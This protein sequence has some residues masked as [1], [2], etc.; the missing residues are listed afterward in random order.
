M[1]ILLFIQK[2]D[3]FSRTE[4]FNLYIVVLHAHNLM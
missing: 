2:E 4:I 1:K 3:F